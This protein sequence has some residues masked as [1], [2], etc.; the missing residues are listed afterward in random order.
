MRKKNF[1]WLWISAFIVLT[2]QLTKGLVLHHLTLGKPEALYPWLNF[3]LRFN[4]GAA[5]SFLH[6]QSGWQRWFLLGVAFFTGI[7]L[8]VWLFRLPKKDRLT[9]MALCFI[10]GGALGNFWDRLTLGYVI[11][12]IEVHASSWY[13]PAFNVAD[14]AIS[15]GAFG[16]VIALW[17][18]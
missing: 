12:F 14:A 4:R 11:D 18:K 15:L 6:H 10:L 3:S 2:D 17:R 16:L 13:F 8:I 7:F 9:Q 5:F 1:L